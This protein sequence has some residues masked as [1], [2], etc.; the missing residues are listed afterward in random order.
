M[1]GKCYYCGK[2]LTE[3]TIKR[4]MKNCSEMKKVIEEKM[5]NTKGI[6]EQFLISIKDKQASRKYCVY[7]SI[8][9][10]LQLAHLDK[11]IRDIWVECC[12]H[13]STF[14]ID[15]EEYSHNS[16]G[17]YKMN[18]LLKDILSIDK[19]FQ[20]KY[21]F[22]L[23]THLILEVVDIIKVSEEFSQIEIIARNNEE[24]LEQA[25]CN[26]P[27]DGV[28]GYSGS[29]EAEIPYLPQNFKEYMINREKPSLS[30]EEECDH[31]DFSYDQHN[32][33]KLTKDSY[34]EINKSDKKWLNTKNCA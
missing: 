29:K 28:C 14:Y 4:H 7:V 12:G 5:E 13:L 3:R 18:F 22:D 30:N 27:R 6:R 16:D 26:S 1:Q 33:D 10:G 20:Y 24:I 23:T 2:E 34:E 9:A 17:Q 8:D 21:D 19:K 11:F 15:R 32:M 31:N 25:Y